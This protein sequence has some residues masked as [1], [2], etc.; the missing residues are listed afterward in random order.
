MIPACL[1]IF[2]GVLKVSVFHINNILKYFKLREE[3][4][5]QNSGGIKVSE[6]NR[7]KKGNTMLGKRDC[8]VLYWISEK[9]EFM[10]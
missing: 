7:V 3:H 10:K 2:I 6:K 1:N 9:D 4:N 8:Q 5:K